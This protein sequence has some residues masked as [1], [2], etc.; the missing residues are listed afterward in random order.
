MPKKSWFLVTALG[1]SLFVLLQ[2][3]SQSSPEMKTNMQMIFSPLFTK[4]STLHTPEPNNYPNGTSTSVIETVKETAKAVFLTTLTPGHTASAKMPLEQNQQIATPSIKQ[5]SSAKEK[6]LEASTKPTTAAPTLFEVSLHMSSQQVEATLGKPDRREPSLF[7]YDW[8]IYNKHPDR[9][10]QV[11]ILKGKV[12]DVFSNSPKA[13]LTNQ[14]RIGTSYDMLKR[15]YSL[16][17]GVTFSYEDTFVEIKNDRAER[18]LQL[19]GDVPVLF[20]LDKHNQQKV[21]GIRIIDKLIL[22]QGG[23]YETKWTYTGEAP[24]FTPPIP[25]AKNQE[26]I[27]RAMERQILDLTNVIRYRYQIPPLRWNEKAAV[28]ARNHSIDMQRNQYFDHISATTGLSPFDRLKENGLSYQMA[29]E[30]ISA[31]FPDAIEAYQSWLNSLGHRKN[32][33][34]KQFEELGVGVS[35]DYFT[36]NF[37]KLSSNK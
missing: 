15:S 30:N 4:T 3:S 1:L 31:G 8:W 32:V 37:V 24:N 21:T 10:V 26:E 18:P 33:L 28:T 29:G 13:A 12:V 35:S 23:F 22:L 14:I 34:E 27:N 36:E 2:A 9:Y 17:E 6:M 19:V 20:Y 5:I 25:D 11:G 7:G 16:Q